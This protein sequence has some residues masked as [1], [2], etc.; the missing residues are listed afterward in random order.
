MLQG[1]WAR[2]SEP[3]AEGT[4]RDALS[5]QARS[6]C[7]VPGSPSSRHQG[8]LFGE[9][10]NVL[11]GLCI[12]FL[13]GFESGLLRGIGAYARPHKLWTF[14]HASPTLTGG[15]AG[16]VETVLALSPRGIIIR[17]RDHEV[18]DRITA[19]GVPV[20][21]INNLPPVPNVG[22][23]CNDNRRIGELAAVHFLSRGHKRFAYYARRQGL[24]DDRLSGF[25]A[26]LAEAG[27]TCEVFEG[28]PEDPSSAEQLAYDAR[29]NAW[30]SALQ[31]PVAIFCD[32]D[33]FAWLMS[34]RCRALRLR[35]PEDIALL[36]VDNVD[37]FATIAQ[38]PLS[39]IQT[40]SDGIG[41][42]A[43]AMLDKML[44]A[45]G[46]IPP[47]LEVPPARVVIRRSS[48][49]VAVS[50]PLLRQ[51]LEHMRNSLLD[52]EGLVLLCERLG[53][54][55][56]TLERRFREELGQSPADAWTRFRVEEAQ[57]LLSETNLS[58][59]TVAQQSGLH[60]SKQMAA[61]FKRTTGR[62]PR[63]FQM[64]VHPGA[65]T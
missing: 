44:T 5:S 25:Q 12:D 10:A 11:I 27:H 30:T 19:A 32:G 59:A 37:S 34:E 1:C 35:V 49:G 40:A 17:T 28:T 52:T 3:A 24:P 63:E 39:S 38:P 65:P 51:V 8:N 31:P 33:R 53:I 29:V 20:V 22:R 62:T 60:S 14:S 36:G 26:R 21:N 42:E 50:D 6:S 4:C 9:E 64:V 54:S 57:R 48:D 45:P 15:A 18:L 56:R 58:L 13:S 43:A 46:K 23:V 2:E 7:L 47:P 61:V 55:R 41:F 16:G